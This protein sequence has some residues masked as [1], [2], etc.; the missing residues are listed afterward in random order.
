MKIGWKREKKGG[1]QGKKQWIS[2]RKGGEMPF[3]PVSAT[4][5]TFPRSQPWPAVGALGALGAGIL[6]G[7][8]RE[9]YQNPQY[10]KGASSQLQHHH[11]SGNP[12]TP[13]QI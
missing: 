3:F 7:R 11:P 13:D 6:Q 5:G 12:P 9:R 8:G 10:P 1:T 4:P 2:E